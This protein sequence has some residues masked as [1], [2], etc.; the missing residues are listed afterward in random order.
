LRYG[1]DFVLCG[2]GETVLRGK[3]NRLIDIGTWCG[4]EKNVNKTTI[5]T[6]DCEGSKKTEECALFQTFGLLG[7]IFRGELN[8]GFVW[9]KMDL[10]RKRRFLASNLTYI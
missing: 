6:T 3:I 5:P 9:Q 2:K 7:A 8:L 10:T 4:M 1:E